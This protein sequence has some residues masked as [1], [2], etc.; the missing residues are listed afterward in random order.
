MD[1]AAEVTSASSRNLLIFYFFLTVKLLG[2]LDGLAA[3]DL[4]VHDFLDE[5]A[6]FITV[7]GFGAL[8]TDLLVELLGLDLEGIN[9]LVMSQIVAV[10]AWDVFNEEV[11]VLDVDDHDVQEEENNGGNHESRDEH[12]FAV[13]E[14]VEAEG[15]E[16]GNAVD[17]Q[18]EDQVLVDLLGAEVHVGIA[19]SVVKLSLECA[20][21]APDEQETE[22]EEDSES[23]GGGV[24]DAV[25]DIEV[26]KVDTF[27]L[28]SGGDD[29]RDDQRDGDEDEDELGDLGEVNIL[30]LLKDKRVVDVVDVHF[31]AVG[32]AALHNAKSNDTFEPD[33]DHEISVNPV[34]AA[35]KEDEA[36]GGEDDQGKHRDALDDPSVV[37]Q[38]DVDVVDDDSDD[39]DDTKLAAIVQVVHKV[40]IDEENNGVEKE[41]TSVD[42]VSDAG[43]VVHSESLEAAAKRVH[44]LLLGDLADGDDILDVMNVGKPILVGLLTLDLLEHV[45]FT[46]GIGDFTFL[47]N[48]LVEEVD[49][50]EL[51]L[52][53]VEV[54]KGAHQHAG[55]GE[56][57][58]GDALEAELA[59]DGR[60]HDGELPGCEHGVGKAEDDHVAQ[61]ETVVVPS[62][63][64]EGSQ[65]KTKADSDQ[66]DGDT[67]KEDGVLVVQL[68]VRFDVFQLVRILK[69]VDA[70]QEEGQEG[71]DDVGVPDNGQVG[72]DETTL[73]VVAKDLEVH[74][75][76]PL[77][78]SEEP[79]VELAHQVLV[80]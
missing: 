51:V 50:V 33:V 16:D 64:L 11:A 58:R 78:H 8:F 60:E 53:E 79:A 20:N 47:A 37:H 28:K 5:A 19:D 63:L 45:V 24:R 72:H 42:T 80:D 18:T 56:E 77:L 54:H 21:P 66:V 40:G 41:K 3:G 17:N 13:H 23:T 61:L 55:L 74:V 29:D 4:H 25:A 31:V 65:N 73:D 26:R 39:A 69:H 44:H 70:P 34:V 22:N 46:L 15:P 71:E 30:G 14:R 6:V 2:E 57:A 7:D 68:A 67:A 38:E 75:V 9:T 52:V 36:A 43:R 59:V 35:T 32:K 76:Q 49:Q 10:D 12:V 48:E 62:D 1:A 27:R